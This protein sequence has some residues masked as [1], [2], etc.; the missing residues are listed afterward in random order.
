MPVVKVVRIDRL[1]PAGEQAKLIDELGR[2]DDLAH[3]WAQPK[4]RH[5]QLRKLVVG[6]FDKARA[7]DSITLQGSMYCV[8][9]S[10]RENVRSIISL[11]AVYERLGRELFLDLADLSLGKLDDHVPRAE[12]GDLVRTEQTGRRTLKIYRRL[13]AA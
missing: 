4:A 8:E 12:Q 13:E 3:Q 5:E 11:D 10:A 1:P 9:V 6:W 2:L 7:T